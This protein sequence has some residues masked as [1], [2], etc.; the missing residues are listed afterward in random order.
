MNSSIEEESNVSVLDA[1]NEDDVFVKKLSDQ[2]QLKD[3]W[4][5]RLYKSSCCLSVVAAMCAAGG[6]F[7]MVMPVHDWKMKEDG[8]HPHH[9]KHPSKHP[10]NWSCDTSVNFMNNGPAYNQI[11]LTDG[12]REDGVCDAN[13]VYGRH[14]DNERAIEYCKEKCDE[15]EQNCEGF[16]FQKHMNN[17]EI[18]GFYAGSMRDYESYW[19]GHQAGAICIHE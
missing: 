13:P 8:G 19:V 12:C 17:H 18:C 4:N 3:K 1:A 7:G 10:R 5:R 6:L 9:G 15:M 2:K 14:C 16:F 11:D